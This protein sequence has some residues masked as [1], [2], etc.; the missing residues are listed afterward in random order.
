MIN[1]RLLFTAISA[2]S[3]FATPFSSQAQDRPFDQTKVKVTILEP[4]EAGKTKLSLKPGEK[5]EVSVEL[6]QPKE[7]Q[8]PNFIMIFLEKK[9][10]RLSDWILEQDEKSSVVNDQSTAKSHRT[11]TIPG[12]TQECELVAIAIYVIPSKTKPGEMDTVRVRS[13]PYKVEKP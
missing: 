10:S 4:A 12:I 1:P 11:I 9:N 5:V 13:N 7:M 2:I 6:K 8:R 3:L